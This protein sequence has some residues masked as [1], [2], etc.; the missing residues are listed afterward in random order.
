[1]TRLQLDYEYLMFHLIQYNDICDH[2][3]SHL[4]NSIWKVLSETLFKFKYNF[5]YNLTQ[6]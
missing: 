1:M 4:N 5:C 2:W 3:Q 6:F